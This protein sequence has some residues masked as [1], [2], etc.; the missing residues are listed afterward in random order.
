MKY[1]KKYNESNTSDLSFSDKY[2]KYI[3]LGVITIDNTR[4][5][6]KVKVKGDLDLPELDDLKIKSEEDTYW[7]EKPAK[8][9]FGDIVSFN[10][11]ELEKMLSKSPE[12]IKSELQIVYNKKFID[13]KL[14]LRKIEI[15]KLFS[16]YL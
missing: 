7:I 4:D 12:E 3:K 1:L 15:R 14:Y 6:I 16:E 5:F 9:D 8:I 13:D 10:S 2:S 11:N